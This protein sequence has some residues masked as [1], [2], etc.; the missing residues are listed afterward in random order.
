MIAREL[1]EKTIG[2]WQQP[3]KEPISIYLIKEDSLARYNHRTYYN[4]VLVLD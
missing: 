1:T 4:L 2:N 3:K